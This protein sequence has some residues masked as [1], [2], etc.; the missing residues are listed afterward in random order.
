MA[1]MQGL[2]EMMVENRVR[3][4]TGGQTGQCPCKDREWWY[5]ERWQPMTKAVMCSDLCFKKFT[6][7][8]RRL[9][10]ATVE[11]GKSVPRFLQ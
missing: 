1:V 5:L 4:I 6:L 7:L 11:A 8:C 10:V 3:E 9:K 2:G